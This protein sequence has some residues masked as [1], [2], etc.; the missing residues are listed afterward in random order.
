VRSADWPS[1]LE[2][3]VANLPPEARSALAQRWREIGQLEHASVASFA[4]F[5]LELL[6]LGAPPELVEQTTSAM[7]DETAHARL[8]FA[9]ASAYAGAPVGPGK[10]D[11]GGAMGD[12]NAC[13][14]LRTL[15]H[16]GCVGETLAATLAR[17][18]LARTPDPVVRGVLLRIAKDEERHALLAW[19][20]LAWLVRGE[21][22]AE[23]SAALATEIQ[24]FESEIA[25]ARKAPPAASP[26]A[27]GN[28]AKYGVLEEREMAELR[29]SVLEGVVI[30]AA[31]S[32]LS[33]R[34]GAFLE[35]RLTGTSATLPIR[36]PL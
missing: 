22:A 28:L 4:R 23:L 29:I 17:E 25:T 3:E 36:L 27:N 1:C 32:L 8:A 20:A 5:A 35:R 19:R 6:S 31:K 18:E 12:L 24:R 7:A 26:S 14:I 30:P 11:V 15:V 13:S 16:E 33:E 10:L 21:A 34:A 9:L 2:P